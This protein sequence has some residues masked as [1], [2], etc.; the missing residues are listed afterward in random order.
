MWDGPE[1]RLSHHRLQHGSYY[2]KQM[3]VMFA[4]GRRVDFLKNDPEGL[5]ETS[6][7]FF[8]P[9]LHLPRQMNVNEGYYYN[10]NMDNLPLQTG[11]AERPPDLGYFLPVF[12]FVHE[13]FLFIIFLCTY[14][15]FAILVTSS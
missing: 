13:I 15:N 12:R 14:M 5:P 6:I 1:S 4:C 8:L 7:F 3:H 2:Q 11:C 9:R 10:I